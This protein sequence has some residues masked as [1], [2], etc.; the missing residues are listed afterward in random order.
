MRPFYLT[1]RS[2]WL[3][4]ALLAYHGTLERILADIA[5]AEP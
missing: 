5:I 1:V 3:L 4:N 2:R